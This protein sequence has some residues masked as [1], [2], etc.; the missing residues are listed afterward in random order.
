MVTTA[1]KRH[2][3]HLLAIAHSAR[4]HVGFH[5]F[6]SLFIERYTGNQGFLF[7]LQDQGNVSIVL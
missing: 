2:H 5:L 7:S 3:C 1:A 6:I 4:Q